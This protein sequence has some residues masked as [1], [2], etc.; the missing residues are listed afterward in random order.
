[1]EV[2]AIEGLCDARFEGVREAFARN[3]A[4]SGELGASVAVA[5]G[6][7]LVVDLWAGH[8][9]RDRTQPWE[10]D[11]LVL[12]YS[13]TKGVVSLAAHM[14]ADRGL[15]DFEAPV[16]DV[17][18]EFAQAGKETLPLRYLLT[19]QAGLPV[20]DEELPVGA[21]LEWDIMAGALARQ[22]PVW[23]PGEKTGY[24]AATF[25][26][27]VGEVIRRVDG[28]SVGTF[29]REE[30]AEPLG[31]EF[32]LGFGP[33]EDNRVSDLHL[34]QVPAEELPSL[35]AAALLEPTSLAARAFNIAPRGPNKGRNSRAYRGSEQPG[36]NGH[37]NARA[38]ATIYGALGSGGAW[39]GHRLLSEEAIRLAG[40]PQLEGRDI[41][42]QTPVRRTLGYMMPV[43]GLPDPRGEN[44]FGHAGMG[45]SLGFCDPD[46]GLGFGYAMNQMWTNTLAADDPR[47]NGLARAVY[48]SLG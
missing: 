2:P 16:A 43:P 24:H 5:L 14:L 33:E 26:W 4:E 10:R 38:L 30:I 47:A 21:E 9:D 20:V 42:L 41:I 13:S 23:E 37:T 27:L 29:I 48:D 19:H 8:V 25:G 44:A 34:A 18:P 45:G 7:E 3:F 6:G 1:M 36:S 35:A 22:A 17:W 40:T 12:V 39:Q 15:I 31:V 46:R 32:L 28:R 11:T